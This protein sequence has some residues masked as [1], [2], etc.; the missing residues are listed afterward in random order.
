MKSINI[1]L[2]SITMLTFIISCSKDDKLI[3]EKK[4]ILMH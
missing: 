4:K 2:A 3:L 1:L